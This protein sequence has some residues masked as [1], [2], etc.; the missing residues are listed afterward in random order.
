MGARWMQQPNRQFGK[1]TPLA[2]MVERGDSGMVAVLAQLDCT[3]AW[4]LTGS[5]G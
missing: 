3:Y 4:D 2:V 5:K 1:R